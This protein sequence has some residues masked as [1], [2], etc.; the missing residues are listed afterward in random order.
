MPGPAPQRRPVASRVAHVSNAQASGGLYADPLRSRGARRGTTSAHSAPVRISR[1]SRQSAG[2]VKRGLIRAAGPVSARGSSPSRVTDGCPMSFDVG[3]GL[4][5]AG[6]GMN[7]ESSNPG[8][9]SSGTGSSVAAWGD[10]VCTAGSPA[11]ILVIRMPGGALNG[12]REPGKSGAAPPC[13][14]VAADGAIP[15]EKRNACIAMEAAM[16]ATRIRRLSL[17][18]A[19]AVAVAHVREARVAPARSGFPGVIACRSSSGTMLARGP[20]PNRLPHAFG[21]DVT[22]PVVRRLSEGGCPARQ[23]ESQLGQKNG[24][25]IDA[26]IASRRLSGPPTFTKSMKRY[27]PGE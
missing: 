10:S 25:Q 17:R 3:G 16:E 7:R 5:G 12:V 20:R 2:F 21:N 6:A 1:I 24:M 13:G 11:T 9:V 8:S 18:R 23:N 22:R 27:P 14:L 15:R 19:S 4:S 26:T